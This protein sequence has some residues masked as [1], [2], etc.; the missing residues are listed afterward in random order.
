MLAI[1]YINEIRRIELETIVP[2]L[3]PGARLLEVGAGSG[4]QALELSRQGFEVSA[5]DLVSSDYADHR[6]FPV[7]D[8]DGRSVPFPDATFDV[9]YSSNVLEHVRDLPALQGEIRRVLKSNGE[10]IHVLPTHG[11]R[12]WTSIAALPAAFQAAFS[13]RDE[14]GFYR[15]LRHAAS[16]ALRRHGE[17][18]N[19]LSEMWYFHPRWWRHHF[20]NQGF[21]LLDDRPIGLFYTAQ[22][23]FG[24]S[25]PLEKRRKLSKM[26]GSSTQLY[27][28][29]RREE[30][31]ESALK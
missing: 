12:F 21:D 7:T 29:A 18:G 16:A 8:Y 11:W 24:T 1:D 31:A 30:S 3:K 5:I 10:C 19:A 17:R 22:M 6:L 27:R 9:V 25:I 15:A 14:P 28:L 23:V 13:K 4:C 20:R 26:I 2:Y